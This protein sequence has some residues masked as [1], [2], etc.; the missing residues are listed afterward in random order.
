MRLIK[1][2]DI[3][4]L[5]LEHENGI[6]VAE[7]IKE[8]ELPAGETRLVLNLL[9]DM[10]GEGTIEDLGYKGDEEIPQNR[11]FCIRGEAGDTP[12]PPQR[13][14]QVDVKYVVTTIIA[15]VGAACGILALV[16]K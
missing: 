7:L 16:I 1:K 10:A 5:L 3:I 13:A 9:S 12:A 15:C 4:R 8:F 2:K 11:C 6:R 14:G